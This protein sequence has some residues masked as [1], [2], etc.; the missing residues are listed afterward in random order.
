MEHEFEEVVPL[1]TRIKRKWRVVEKKFDRIATNM[2]EGKYLKPATAV[3][4]VATVVGVAF[5]IVGY[6]EHHK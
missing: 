3:C 4:A 6:N 1:K 2:H 5:G